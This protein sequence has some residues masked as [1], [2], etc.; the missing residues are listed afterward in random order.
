M[1]SR[2]SFVPISIQTKA[3]SSTSAS[4]SR[5]MVMPDVQPSVS[6]FVNP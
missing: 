3:T 6:A 2:G 4:T 1:G 5:P